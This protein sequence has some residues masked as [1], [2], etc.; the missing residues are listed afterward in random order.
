[1]RSF[2]KKEH[3]EVKRGHSMSN[4]SIV[5][6]IT[7]KNMR[8]H[9]VIAL[10][11]VLM[12]IVLALI[13]I[14]KT[15]RYFLAQKNVFGTSCDNYKKGK[16]YK[17]KLYCIYDYFGENENG[18]FY[19]APV[20]NDA[21][22]D[23]YLI[24]FIPNKYEEKAISIIE[25]TYDYID[26][27]DDSVLVES[28]NCRGYLEDVDSITRS[29]VNEYFDYY[30]LP[31]TEKAKV[32][33]TEFVM[34]PVEKVLL[35]ET[36]A[37]LLIILVIFAGAVVMFITAFT[38]GYLKNLKKR[39]ARENMTLAD[40]DAE[41]SNPIINVDDI[42]VSEKHVVHAS[43]SPKILNIADV[44]WLYPTKAAAV[45]SNNKPIFH[46]FFYTKNHECVK[47][48]VREATSSEVLCQAVHS[49][50]PRAL[51]GYLPENSTMY[52]Q[53]FNELVDQVYNQK[54]E[55]SSEAIPEASDETNADPVETTARQQSQES[56]V[57]EAP[58]A[59]A[60][61]LTPSSVAPN[62]APDDNEPQQ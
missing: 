13:E 53:H 59:P 8:I 22:E 16:F 38:K 3:P 28:I 18:K 24:V 31:Q 19:L 14:P 25:Q 10:V 4:F 35:S 40:L 5:K 43:A 29:Y 23:R 41:F 34:Y 9:F 37:F 48:D 27:G 60:D 30:S 61:I 50:Q 6:K 21:G 54:E 32:C 45:S 56:P 7:R 15:T 2:H 42:Y 12:A 44:I 26:T 57:S 36:G 39:L 47:F 11:L 58:A 49:V 55:T 62:Q 52:Y 20:Q 1:M 46:S 17:G 51:Y 33:D